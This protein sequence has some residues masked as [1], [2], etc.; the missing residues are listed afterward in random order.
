MWGGLRRYFFLPSKS[1]A[2]ESGLIAALP[3]RYETE[4]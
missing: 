2:M 4:W 1:F 3:S